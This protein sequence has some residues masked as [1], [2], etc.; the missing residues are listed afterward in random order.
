MA[1]SALYWVC[2][3]LGMWVLARGCGLDLSVMGAFATMGLIAV[4]ITLPNSPGLVG[5]FHWFT[6]LGLSLYLPAAVARSAGL[7]YAILLHGIQ[8]VWYMALGA[9][10]MLTSHVSFHDLLAREPEA[11]PGDAGAPSSLA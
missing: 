1:W 5:Q 10:S 8:V 6:T 11:A 2:N 7:G 3:G 9:I 4:G